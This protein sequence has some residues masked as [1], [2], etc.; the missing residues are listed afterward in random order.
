FETGQ[1]EVGRLVLRLFYIF[2]RNGI[3][4]VQDY[5]LMAKAILS[6]EES[7]ARLDPD[8]DIR[9]M[10]IPAIRELQQERRNPK[11]MWKEAG[12]ALSVALQLLKEMP[13]GFTRILRRVENDD[14]TVQFQ[15]RGLEEVSDSLNA[16]SNRVTLGVIIGSLLIGSSL[17][18]TTGIQPHLLGYP[19]LGMVGYLLSAILGLWIIVDII[20]HGRHR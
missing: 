10:A 4:V 12:M 19:A 13:A 20:R 18:I 9:K 14:L 17:I 15:H 8:F 6:I 1:G 2:A 11:T 5:S 3:D 7:G 16:A